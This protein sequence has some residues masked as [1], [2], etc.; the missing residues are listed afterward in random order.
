MLE[1]QDVSKALR[2]AAFSTDVSMSIIYLQNYTNGYINA[3]ETNA[4]TASKREVRFF[5]WPAAAFFP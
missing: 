5:E 3:A 2:P 4:H 1:I